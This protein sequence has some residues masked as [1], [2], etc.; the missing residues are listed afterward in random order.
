MTVFPFHPWAI[1]VLSFFLPPLC[2]IIITIKLSQETLK[3]PSTLFTVGDISLQLRMDRLR[4]DEVLIETAAKF[5]FELIRSDELTK[6]SSWKPG[7]M[8]PREES[9]WLTFVKP[10]ARCI[11]LI[12]QLIHEKKPKTEENVK[13]DL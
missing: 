1:T 3:L 4:K 13:F 5:I 6:D 2:I 10:K 12:N 7:V 9:K 8:S 11:S